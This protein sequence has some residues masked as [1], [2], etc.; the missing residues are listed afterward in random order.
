M[1]APVKYVASLDH[2]REVSLLGSADLAFWRERLKPE[3]L[4]AE[5]RDG[6]AQILIV[7]AEAKFRG[8]RF[9]ELSFSVM[10]HGGMFLLRALNSRR[11][12]AF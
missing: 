3:G 11:F 7:G 5:E 8:I 6:R 9:S 1:T 10:V 2:V 4:E 12:F